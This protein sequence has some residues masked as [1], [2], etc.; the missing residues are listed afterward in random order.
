M[1]CVAC[2]K[3]LTDFEATRKVAATGEFLGMCNYCFSYSAEDIDTLERHDLK[4]ERDCELEDE[5][6]EQDD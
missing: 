2:N 5:T 1:R 4:S 3:L 6:Y